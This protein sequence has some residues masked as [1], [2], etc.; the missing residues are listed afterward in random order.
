MRPTSSRRFVKKPERVEPKGNM[1]APVP[2]MQSV[3]EPG[4]GGKL[5]RGVVPTDGV[6]Q[7]VILDIGKMNKDF[8]KI[9]ATIIEGTSDKSASFQVEKGRNEYQVPMKV[10]AG[11]VFII[12]L[13][14]E[15]GLEV[16]D[17]AFGFSIVP[18]PVAYREPEP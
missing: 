14:E 17:I 18:K 4:E 1:S 7:N 6:V 2:V 11:S 5:F 12:A 16:C 13:E 8:A 3:D 9:R 15:E 10:T